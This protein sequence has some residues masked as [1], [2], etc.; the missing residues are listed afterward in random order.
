MG[1][2]FTIDTTTKRTI[3]SMAECLLAPGEINLGWDD[4]G[5]VLLQ[6]GETVI[7]SGS[8]TGESR[9]IKACDDALSSYRTAAKIVQAEGGLNRLNEDVSSFK[10]TVPRREPPVTNLYA[11]SLEEIE[12][13]LSDISK[14]PDIIAVKKALKGFLPSKKLSDLHSREG[15]IQAAIEVMKRTRSVGI[16]SKGSYKETGKP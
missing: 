10:R 2:R 15:L 8:G 1:K 13:E 9:A 7:A 3:I 11:L 4:I 16:F 14:Y 5:N 6:R 12:K